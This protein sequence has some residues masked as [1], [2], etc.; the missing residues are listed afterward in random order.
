MDKKDQNIV[1]LAVEDYLHVSRSCLDYS[2][3]VNG[4]VKDFSSK[5]G[6]VSSGSAY[7]REHTISFIRRFQFPNS[8]SLLTIEVEQ[9]LNRTHN[10]YR[11]Q[12]SFLKR[13]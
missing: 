1:T 3:S 13:V 9:V 8:C 11:R 10:E 6:D 4:A 7:I 2:V 5:L 12:A